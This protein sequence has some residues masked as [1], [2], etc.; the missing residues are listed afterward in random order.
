[1]SDFFRNLRTVIHPTKEEDAGERVWVGWAEREGA[2]GR[3][4]KRRERA[5]V[6]GKNW[7]AKVFSFVLRKRKHLCDDPMCV[8]VMADFM[9]QPGEC[10]WMR[11]TFR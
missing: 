6:L 3:A 9:C 5:W 11:L 8:F 2:G 10:V 7:I 4:Q 1:M